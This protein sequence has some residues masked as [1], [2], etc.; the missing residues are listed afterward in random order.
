MIKEKLLNIFDEN[1]FLILEGEE[2]TPLDIDSIQFISVIDW[3]QEWI[4]YSSSIK[5]VNQFFRYN[6]SKLHGSLM[7]DWIENRSQPW[8]D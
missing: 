1:G 8:W 4:V 6:L 3:C 7:A 5:S 2:D